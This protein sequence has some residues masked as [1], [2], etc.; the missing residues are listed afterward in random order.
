M[1]EKYRVKK[2]LL[3]GYGITIGV[4]LFLIVTSL[5]MMSNIKSKYDVLLNKEAQAS[6]DILY[7]RVNSLLTGRNI[8]DCYLTPGSEANEGLLQAAEKAQ[9]DLFANMELLKEHFP[10]Q[11]DRSKLD[12]YIA[13]T[14]NWADTNPQLI[15]WYRQYVKTGDES[16]IQKGIQFIYET[17]TPDQENMAAAAT[18]LDNYL[19]QATAD[20]RERIEFEV[21]VIIGIVA[22]ATVLATIAVIALGF[23]IIKTITIP[24]GQVQS[25]LVGFSQGNLDISVDYQ[26]KSELGVMCDALRSS[27]ATLSGVIQDEAYLLKEMAEGN[28]DVHSKDTSLYVGALETIIQSIRDINH[29]L[30]DALLRIAQGTDQVSAGADQVS[31]GAQSLAQGATEQASTL[32]E[33]T[34]TITEISEASQKTDLAAKEA[35]TSVQAA[36]E[37]V[38]KMNQQVDVLN[39]AMNKIAL[40]SQEMGKIIRTIEDIAFQ[41]NILALNAAVEAARAGSAGKG[42]AVVADEVRSLA[43]KSDASAKATKELIDSAISSV[44]D[45]NNIV[46]QVTQALMECKGLT[47]EVVNR[48][49]VV[50]DGV[51]VQ[52]TSIKQVT[53]SIDQLSSVVQTNSA[54]SEESA[55]ASEEL[56]SQAATMKN[57]VGHFTLR[58]I[59]GSARPAAPV[60]YEKEVVVSNM[61]SD[62]Y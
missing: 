23:V 45:G 38:E 41:T 18:A 52:T 59:D 28:F 49:D 42:F 33:L 57:L 6:Q 1:E 58:R 44:Q 13:V 22:A 9:D 12:E 36:G 20:E 37:Q 46:E 55:A 7:C 60:P 4:S 2:C 40:S 11:L 32:E 14:T 24:V 43:A 16:Y 61:S 54:T 27:Q 35:K 17:D 3:L 51:E 26:S 62:K 8:R 19:V 25:A 39:Q 29:Q 21:M 48:V 50:T 5:F 31:T 56:A 47:N 34:A 15:E 30:S 53:E 10:S